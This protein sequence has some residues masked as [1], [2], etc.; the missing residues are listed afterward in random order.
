MGI[1]KVG[2]IVGTVEALG[3]SMTIRESSSEHW[4]E[5]E[6][7]P[8]FL[9]HYGRIVAVLARLLG[10]SSRAEEVANDAFW[11][12]YRQPALQNDGNVGGWL[13]RT[14]T[15]LGIDSLRTSGRRRQYEDAASRAAEEGNAKG[16]L[17]DLLREETCRRVRDVLASIK[18]AQAQLLILRSSGLSYRELADAVHVKMS[19]I[20]TMLN[21]AEEE[22]R[23]RYH[24][25]YPHEE[26]L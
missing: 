16:P 18:P 4:D 11:R 12:L 17:D 8:I 9:R 20:G 13:Y 6:F 14:A 21:R 19:G 5:G 26:A 3:G 24:A 25:L 23:N 10:D 15:N 1:R 22:F 7:R 2:I